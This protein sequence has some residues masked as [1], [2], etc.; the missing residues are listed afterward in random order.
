V[1]LLL[2]TSVI[3]DHL[4]G[5]ARAVG[6]LREAVEA[7]DELWSLTVVRTE[8]LAG[9]RRGEE[10][11]T[12]ALLGALRWQDVSIEIADR[13]GDLARRY[14]KR[15]PGVDTIDYLLAACALGLE[16]RLL[17]KNVKHFPM[18][19]ELTAPY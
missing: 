15:F 12:L 11:S 13:A 7:G 3:I 1:K 17:T 8:V 18:L 14:L 4:R 10:A 19:A 16:A 2:D 9:M 6:L 5:D